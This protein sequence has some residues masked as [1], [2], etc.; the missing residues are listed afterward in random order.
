METTLQGMLEM[1]LGQTDSKGQTAQ[2]SDDDG[3]TFGGL[4]LQKVLIRIRD[5]M[6]FINI[7]ALS[8]QRLLLCKMIFWNKF[9]KKVMIE[10]NWF[11][12]LELWIA[13]VIIVTIQRIKGAIYTE[14]KGTQVQRY[15][16]ISMAYQIFS[17]PIRNHV[18]LSWGKCT[19]MVYSHCPTAKPIKRQIKMGC[20][21]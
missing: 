13:T 15:Q 4:F 11:S 19:L 1:G 5:P 10:M 18:A 3:I 12:F 17:E 14:R 8:L 2:D 21:E 20:I 6:E 7:N 9:Q 16:S